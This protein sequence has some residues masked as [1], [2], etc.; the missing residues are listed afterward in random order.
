[1]LGNKQTVGADPDKSELSVPFLS[2]DGTYFRVTTLTA[3]WDTWC[4]GGTVFNTGRIAATGVYVSEPMYCLGASRKTVTLK[5]VIDD[6][7]AKPIFITSVW[8]ADQQN[9]EQTM[10]VVDA[11]K[12]IYTVFAGDDPQRRAIDV[13]PSAA[14]PLLS[15]YMA[16]KSNVY[17]LSPLGDGN[18][19]TA[20]QMPSGFIPELVDGS[21][22]IGFITDYLAGVRNLVTVSLKGQEQARVQLPPAKSN[23][24]DN[25]AGKN[26]RFINLDAGCFGDKPEV[27]ANAIICK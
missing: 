7:K 4:T 23:C 1:M 9:S 17:F 13:F 24:S 20:N 21:N 12:G 8:N 10:Q 27:W 15:W 6:G 2:F 26:G 16:A 3:G 11:T 18:V 14:G 19:V 22:A 25:L 5:S